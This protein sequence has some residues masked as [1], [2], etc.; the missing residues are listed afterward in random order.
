M[1]HSLS[2]I[3]ALFFILCVVLCSFASAATGGVPALNDDNDKQQSVLSA[4]LRGTGGDQ[5][6]GNATKTDTET[7]DEDSYRYLT[8][9]IA[10]TPVAQRGMGATVTGAEIGSM[11]ATG[12]LAYDSLGG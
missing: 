7:D 2:Y 10:D 6:Y 4:Y 11:A 12:A 8:N 1:A 5:L 3:I 9:R